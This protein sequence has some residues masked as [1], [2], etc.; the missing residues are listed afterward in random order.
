MLMKR[1]KDTLNHQREIAGVFA[2]AGALLLIWKG[3]VALGASLLSGMLA[4][5]VGEHNGKR[6]KAS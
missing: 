5:F 3:E 1:S 6:Q 4:F 2:G